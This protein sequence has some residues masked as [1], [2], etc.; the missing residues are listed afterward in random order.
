LHKFCQEL[1]ELG[2]FHRIQ[3]V[4]Q[5]DDEVPRCLFGFGEGLA[6]AVSDLHR[7]RPPVAGRGPARGEPGALMADFVTT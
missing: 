1:D 4:R 6:P 2:P 7:V 5:P 3:V